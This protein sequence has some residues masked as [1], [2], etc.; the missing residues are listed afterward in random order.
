MK[1]RLFHKIGP[2]G[3]D[4]AAVRQ[5]VVDNGLADAIEFS[6][7]KYDDER[8]E[9]FE[10]AGPKADA[11]LLLVDGRPIAGRAAIIDWLKTNLLCLRD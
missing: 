2:D 10:L 11:P 9:L 5:F 6:N 1:L 7:I 4:S 8:Q 3:A